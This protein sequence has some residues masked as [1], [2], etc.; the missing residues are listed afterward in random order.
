MTDDKHKFHEFNVEVTWAGAKDGDIV[1]DGK[2]PLTI[3]SPPQWGGRKEQYSPQELFVSSV[4][5]CF[6]TTLA[7]MMEKMEQP[8]TSH[9]VNGRAVLKRHP[10]GGWHFTDIYITM[11]ITIPKEAS[12]SKVKRAIQLTEKYCHVSRSLTSKLHIKP[13]ITQT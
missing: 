8:L 11:D 2:P 13:Q 7:T 1:L 6:I 10:E 12:V 9:N 4:A 5:S 3:S